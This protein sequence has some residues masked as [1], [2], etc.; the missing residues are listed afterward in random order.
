MAHH[1]YLSPDQ[2]NVLVVEMGG[3][4]QLIACR[5][6][7][8]AQPGP[9]RVIGPVDRPCISGAWSPDGK[10]LY[11]NVATDKYH[12]WRTRF[13]DGEAEQLTFGPTSQEGM[14][15]APDG[16]SLVTSVGSQDSTVWLHDK[17]GDHQISSE[18][19]AEMPSFSADGKS[20]YFLMTSGPSQKR[21]L[22]EKELSGENAQRLVPGYAMNSYSVSLDGKSVVYATE[23]KNGNSSIWIASTNRRFSPKQLSAQSIDDSP[24]FRPDGSLVFRSREAGSNFMY[25]MNADGSGRQK[26]SPDTAFDIHGLSPDGRWF[27]ASSHTSD[28]E[29]PVGVRAFPVDGGEPV[30]LCLTYCATVWDPSGKFIFM[31]MNWENPET[32][33]LPTAPGSQ[34]PEAPPTQIREPKDVANIAGAVLIHDRV[35]TALSPS[36]YA[37][38]RTTT[39]RNLYRIPLH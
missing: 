16:K 39:R 17:S 28:P 15:M 7:P 30:T 22:W 36:V 4:G 8:F 2:K 29:H 11:F 3:G 1:S 19:S 37:F 10:W 6:V 21:E 38:A 26:I 5:V 25:R 24:K 27:V 35:E 9:P 31:R 34:L 18:G 20:I 14:A 12:I 33:V 13:P 32:Y 23:D